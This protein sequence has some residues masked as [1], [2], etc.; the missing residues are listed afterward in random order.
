MS[1]IKNDDPFLFS[2]LLT[3]SMTTFN[4]CPFWVLPTMING[5]EQL[6]IR[7]QFNYRFSSSK[8]LQQYWGLLHHNCS[9]RIKNHRPTYSSCPLRHLHAHLH[10]CESSIP[11]S[12]FVSPDLLQQPGFWLP[13]RWCVDTYLTKKE[14]R[15]SVWVV[16]FL[17]I[18]SSFNIFSCFIFLLA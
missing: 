3:S 2:F 17:D 4:L 6:R 9:I 18:S 7:I 1:A 13:F 10:F 15:Q 16:F 11:V 12:S 14:N 8:L 5:R